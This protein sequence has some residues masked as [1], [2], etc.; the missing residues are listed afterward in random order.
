MMLVHGS[1]QLVNKKE[2]VGWGCIWDAYIPFWASGGG[3]GRG[4]LSNVFPEKKWVNLTEKN[5]ASL[6][7][8]AIYGCKPLYGELI[9]RSSGLVLRVS[10]LHSVSVVAG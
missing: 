2:N 8:Y 10:Y 9:S 3:Q 4:E 6:V 1:I 5:N 7:S